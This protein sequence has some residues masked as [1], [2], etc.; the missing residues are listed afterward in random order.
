[1]S[2]PLII[3]CWQEKNNIF[4]MVLVASA[5]LNNSTDASYMEAEWSGTQGQL[6]AFRKLETDRFDQVSFIQSW[7]RG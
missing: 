2:I 7:K 5:L 6:E 3:C 1:V 4:F